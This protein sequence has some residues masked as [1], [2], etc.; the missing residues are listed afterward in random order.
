[1]YD[2]WAGASP[3]QPEAAAS[4]QAIKNNAVFTCILLKVEQ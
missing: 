4:A 1:M 3:H 2:R